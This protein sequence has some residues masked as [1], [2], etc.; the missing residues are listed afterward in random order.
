VGGDV[1]MAVTLPPL[2]QIQAMTPQARHELADELKHDTALHTS[3]FWTCKTCL[4][5]SI[6]EGRAAS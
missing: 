5:I 4:W 2:E 1:V 6:L 3:D